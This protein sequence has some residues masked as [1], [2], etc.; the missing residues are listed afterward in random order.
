MS[1]I[2]QAQ[3]SNW[4]FMKKRPKKKKQGQTVHRHSQLLTF[5]QVRKWREEGCKGFMCTGRPGW[6]SVSLRVG[7][8]KK[9]H[10]NIPINMMDI[11]EVDTQKQVGENTRPQDDA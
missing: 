9:T 10:R 3:I 1:K 11:L 6:L 5:F 7:K 2:D 8:Y 4:A